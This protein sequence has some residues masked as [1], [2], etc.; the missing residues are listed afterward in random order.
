VFLCV[1]VMSRGSRG[2]RGLVRKVRV[3]VARAMVKICCRLRQRDESRGGHGH[4]QRAGF[5]ERRVRRRGCK[6]I[7]VGG[8]TVLPNYSRLIAHQRPLDVSNSCQ[9]VIA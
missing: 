8:E 1:N 4:P 3:V 2:R 7:S 5:K 6:G 9:P